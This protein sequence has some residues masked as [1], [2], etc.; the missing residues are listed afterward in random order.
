MFESRNQ[1]DICIVVAFAHEAK[2]LIEFWRLKKTQTI[3][4]YPLYEGKYRDKKIALLISGVGALNTAQ[5]L[6]WCFGSSIADNHTCWLNVGIAGHSDFE[7]GTVFSVNK[8]GYPAG[9]GTWYPSRILKRKLPASNI[10]CVSKPEAE[11]KE[12]GAYDMETAGFFSALTKFGKMELAHSIKVV[13]DNPS[14]SW[15]LLDK[16]K[17]SALIHASIPKLEEFLNLLL[18]IVKCEREIDAEPKQYFTLLEKSHFTETQKHQL[19]KL[20]L[21]WES[22]FG[23]EC[24]IERLGNIH[25]SKAW[26]KKLENA[27]NQPMAI[28]HD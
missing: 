1:V 22:Y 24:V 7:I 26:L 25:H 9:N 4:E 15:K 28:D 6:A 12:E 5:A 10:I 11:Y 27:L 8:C 2:P 20:L 3:R 13:S 16:E 17:I 14:S 23:A 18:E 19:F 21:R